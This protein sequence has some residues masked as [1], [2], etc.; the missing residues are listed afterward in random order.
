MRSTIFTERFVRIKSL[1]TISIRQQTMA[2]CQL[3]VIKREWSELPGKQTEDK[4]MHE[5]LILF[6]DPSLGF[7][8]R[9]AL[10]GSDPADIT[11]RRLLLREYSTLD[12]LAVRELGRVRVIVRHVSVLVN[13]LVHC[14]GRC[15]VLVWILGRDGILRRYCMWLG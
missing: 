15:V 3:L 4:G 10:P 12:I 9:G 6:I 1:E 14:V 11:R 8:T 7:I 5:D 13:G 2:E